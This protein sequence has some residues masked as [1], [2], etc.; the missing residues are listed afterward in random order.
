MFVRQKSSPNS[1]RKTVQ[2]V[3][4]IRDGQRVK[5]RIVRHVGVASDEEELEKLLELAQYL[6]AQLEEQHTPTLFGPDKMANLALE[7]RESKGEEDA[8]IT[9]DLRKLREEQ[10]IIVGI[11]DIYG[12]IYQQLGFDQVLKP[13]RHGIS[14]ANILRHIVM[15]R[16]ANPESKRASV[17]DLED[18]FGVNLNLYN[19]YRMMDKLDEEACEKMQ[20]CAY[21]S[22]IDLFGGKIDGVLAVRMRELNVSVC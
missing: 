14:S 5:Q 22:A 15:A 6:K 9:V 10:R 18:D 8:P 19:V 4:S 12:K 17:I 2:I 3:E 20:R 11:H 7:T 13:S 21:Q 16:I 1:P